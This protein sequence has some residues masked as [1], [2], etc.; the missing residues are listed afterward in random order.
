VQFHLPCGGIGVAVP[1]PATGIADTAGTA[2]SV[3][4]A[5]RVGRTGRV[6]KAGRVGKAGKP[7]KAGK[8]GKVGRVGRVGKVGRVGSLITGAADTPRAA[9]MTTRMLVNCIFMMRWWL[10]VDWM[11]KMPFCR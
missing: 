6:D 11:W 5:F 4:R 10:S 9:V 2:G 1:L 8:V 7:G 3:G